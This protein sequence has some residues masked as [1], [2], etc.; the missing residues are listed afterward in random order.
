M[1]LP[2]YRTNAYKCFVNKCCYETYIISVC[3]VRVSF[4]LSQSYKNYC[5]D[6]FNIK[7]LFSNNQISK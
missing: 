4:C 1:I 7:I 6:N 5:S 3:L 2:T